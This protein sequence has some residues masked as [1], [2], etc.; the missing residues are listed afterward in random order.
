MTRASAALKG[1]LGV[2]DG[3]ARMAPSARAA[4]KVSMESKGRLVPLASV[5]SP[6]QWASG[7]CR[8]SVANQVLRVAMAL[9][10]SAERRVMWESAGHK[11]S[12]GPWVPPARK[13][14][15]D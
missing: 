7:D 6:A 3:T 11:V 5:A 13:A 8:A 4:R 9:Q 2:T 12:R 10:E 1:Q 14:S 15:A